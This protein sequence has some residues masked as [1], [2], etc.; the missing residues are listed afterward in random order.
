MGTIGL[1]A[2]ALLGAGPFDI[3]DR[4]ETHPPVP[5][6]QIQP[7][8]PGGETRDVVVV[9]YIVVREDGSVADLEFIQGGPRFAEATRVALMQWRYQPYLIDGE[10]ISWKS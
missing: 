10:A 6:V 4:M 2:L 8:D 5:I 7:I 9:V 3:T 1:L